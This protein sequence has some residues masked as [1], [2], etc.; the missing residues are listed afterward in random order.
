MA[1]QT[2]LSTGT[3]R[4]RNTGESSTS[5]AD[6]KRQRTSKDPK[7][8]HLYTDDNPQTTLHG[9]GF[10]DADTAHRTLKLVS[11]RSLT[12]QFQTINTLLC[13]ARTHK[14]KTPGMEA[15]MKIF[16][17]WIDT[18]G[19]QKAAVRPFRL[20]SKNNVKVYLERYDK[21]EYGVEGEADGELKDAEEF[22]RMYVDLEARKRLA[23]ILYDNEHPEREDWEVRRYKHLCSL[24]DEGKKYEVGDLWIDEL[25]RLPTKMHLKM[26]LWAYSPSPSKA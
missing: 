14:H 23:N 11:Q 7:A 13:R 12:Y 24:V 22:A 21:G 25:D 16:Q 15:S 8:S 10:K 5:T 6:S 3:K 4:S 20:L 2:T 9:T 26:I 1:R 18:F 17:E 19:D